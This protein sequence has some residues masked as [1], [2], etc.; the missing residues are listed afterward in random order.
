MLISVNEL[1]FVS[2]V[3][4]IT[5][6]FSSKFICC[7]F[8]CLIYILQFKI[9][10]LDFCCGVKMQNSKDG[11]TSLFIFAPCHVFLRLFSLH[12]EREVEPGQTARFNHLL[13]SK[14]YTYLYLNLSRG[15]VHLATLHILLTMQISK[16]QRKN[17]TFRICTVKTKI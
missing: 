3:K 12:R 14:T 17:I 15:F 4:L 13:S 16:S 9:L 10:F 8:A 5:A 7:I 11:K 2:K 6:V 1:N